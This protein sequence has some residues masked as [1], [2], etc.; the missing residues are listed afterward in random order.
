MSENPLS[1]YKYRIKALQNIRDVIPNAM[2]QKAINLYI[3]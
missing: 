1:Q 2:M 3:G